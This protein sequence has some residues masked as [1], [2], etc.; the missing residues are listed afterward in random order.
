M[1]ERF[2]PSGRLF[3]EFEDARRAAVSVQL[4]HA[5]ALI[6]AG[7]AALL[8]GCPDIA[9][10]AGTAG[11]FCDVVVTDYDDGLRRAQQAA[12]HRSLGPQRVL[13]V[14]QQDREWDVRAAVKAG[15]HG[16]VLQNSE[17]GELEAAV[18]ALGNGQRYLT[19]VLG[20]SL[21]DSLAR[22]ELTGREVD[23]LREMA[24][25]SC[26]KSIARDL[27]IGV[28][29]VKTHVKSLLDKLGATARTHA[30]VL[31]AQRGLI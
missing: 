3:S 4:R 25:G 11:G 29:T 28:G 26:N 27:G 22:V 24:R 19:P 2:A 17:P 8:D 5:S 30:V 7:L 20:R 16:Y 23:V 13:I 10:A 21:A 18:R 15:V 9:L 12:V 14:T 6:C 1:I 31:A